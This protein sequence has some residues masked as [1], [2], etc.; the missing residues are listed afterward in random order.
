MG[1]T[2]CTHPAPLDPGGGG[3]AGAGRGGVK[4]NGN[5]SVRTCQISPFSEIDFLIYLERRTS[6]TQNTFVLVR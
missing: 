5:I 2:Q 6:L 4:A 1:H 3:G